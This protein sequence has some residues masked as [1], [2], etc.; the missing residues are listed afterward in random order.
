LAQV[1]SWKLHDPKAPAFPEDFE[2]VEKAVLQLT[3]IQS[4][5][6]KYYA[7]EIHSSG[8]L[9][10][11]F[12]HYGRTDD[13]ENDPDAGAKECRYF[14]SLVDAQVTYQSIYREKTS[15]RKG[16]KELSLASSRIGSTKARGTS[17]GQID[18]ATL[19]KAAEAEAAKKAAV[20]PPSESPVPVAKPSA[21][22]PDVPATSE[23]TVDVAPQATGWKSKLKKLVGK[24]TGSEATLAPAPVAPMV[25]ERPSSDG[26]LHPKVAD[27]VEYVYAEATNALTSTVAAK[28][29]AQGIETPL[30]ILTLGQIQKGEAI[31]QDLYALFQ[32]KKKSQDEVLRLSGDFYTVVPHRIGRTRAAA[33]AA[34]IDTL[35]AFEQKQ[36]TLQLMKDMLQVIGQGGGNVLFESKAHAQYEALRCEIGWVDPASGTFKEIR[37]LV[38]NSQIKTKAIKVQSVYTLRRE[39]EWE[40]FAAHVDNQRLLFHGSRIK[41]WVGILSRGILLPKIVVSM[42]VNRTDAGWLGNGIYF[43]DAA[44]TSAFYTSA[45]KRN[46]RFMSVARVA[47]GRMKDFTKITYG[48]ERP[49][50][51]YQSCHGVRNKIGSPSQFADDEYVVYGPSQQRLEYLV[52]FRM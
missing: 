46:T 36:E 8:V 52:E 1:K 37:D 31:L 38:L 51:G 17:S 29:T 47:L 4:N 13:L 39:P 6:N 23:P 40:A 30:G 7:I 3:D 44:C 42:G 28:I 21:P 16:Y 11:V 25:V 33:Q 32:Q 48:L 26:P 20:A 9:F 5:H 15:P 43:G 27:L 19:K 49:P 22:A 24:V 45:G 18:D 34:V 35:E 14:S 10:R 50:E 12:T 2:V 41:N